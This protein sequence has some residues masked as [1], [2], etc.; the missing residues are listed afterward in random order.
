MKPK[1]TEIIESKSI[2]KDRIIVRESHRNYPKGKSNIYCSDSNGNILWFSAVP[3]ENDCYPN[4]IVWNSRINENASGWGD[5]YKSSN[6]S[7]VVSSEK[8]FTVTINI[9]NG[10]II[11][12]EFTK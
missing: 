10:K 6:D 4:N 3:F 2:S 9:N 11:Q 5:F 1:F 12:T 7:F 8:G